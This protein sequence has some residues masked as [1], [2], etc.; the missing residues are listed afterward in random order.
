MIIIAKDTIKQTGMH[1]YIEGFKAYDD[2]YLY[3]VK[4]IEEAEQ[5]D[6]EIG[7]FAGFLPQEL[8]KNS[9]IKRKFYVYCSP[10][11]QADLSSFDFYSVEI[12]IL[13]N[14]VN[15]RK[16]GH[17]ENVIATSS[18]LAERFSF[19]YVPAYGN[20][21]IKFDPQKKDERKNYGFLGNNIRKHRNV[22][23]QLSAIS[24]LL[25]K[26]EIIVK[27]ASLYLHWAWLYDCKVSSRV[28]DSDADYYKEIATHRLNF[29]CTHSESFNYISL[30]Y[31]L[32][33]VPSIVSPC[34]SWMPNYS[35]VKNIDDWREIKKVAS[36][37]LDNYEDACYDTLSH[38]K[39]ENKKRKI[40]VVEELKKL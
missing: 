29:Q 37:V 12:Q 40:F 8:L 13:L 1:R 14:L 33:G 39:M 27:D 3:F 18:S 23:N 34:I 5:F 7:I 35:I 15:L 2:C 19:V 10:L 20:A 25:P 36:N 9:S 28:L 17:I 22:A 6:S 4:N 26:E 38:C 24:S 11:G 30:E 31:G 16:S 32:S 21:I